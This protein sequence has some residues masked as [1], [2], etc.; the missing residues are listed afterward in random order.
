MNLEKIYN[1]IEKLENDLNYYENRL[2]SLKSLVTPQ[3]TKFDKVVVDGGKKSNN[4]LKYVEVENQQQLEVTILYIKAKLRDLN[5]LKDK[6]IE[7]LTKYGE[8]IKVVVLLKER[9]FKVIYK[10]GRKTKRHLTWQEIAD[11]IPCSERSARYWYKL[12]IEER[13]R[14]LS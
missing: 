12:G 2:E 4:I 6:E 3:A 5:N 14:V 10:K 11:K 7:R 13:K 1:E 8:T 9:E